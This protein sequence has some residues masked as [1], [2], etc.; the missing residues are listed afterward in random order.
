M[1]AFAYEKSKS[2]QRD[3]MDVCRKRR[4]GSELGILIKNL[5]GKEVSSIYSELG[6]PTLILLCGSI[7]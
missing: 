2:T 4:D 6:T 5:N 3:A 7:Y 1:L